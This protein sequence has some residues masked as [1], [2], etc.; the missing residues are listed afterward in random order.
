MIPI[1][2]GQGLYQFEALA[3]VP[4]MHE[5]TTGAAVGESETLQSDTVEQLGN[6]TEASRSTPEAKCSREAIPFTD[7]HPSPA[8]MSSSHSG[9]PWNK[10]PAIII[11]GFNCV[12]DMRNKMT[13]LRPPQSA[14][15]GLCSAHCCC[16]LAIVGGGLSAQ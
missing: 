7:Q 5:G 13:S 15:C 2:S 1:F 11:W 9:I 6:I 16:H 12:S 4:I 10:F 14:C 8:P 3:P